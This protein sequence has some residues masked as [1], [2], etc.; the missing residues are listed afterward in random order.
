MHRNQCL[1]I[2]LDGVMNWAM[3]P[4]PI[5][6]LCLQDCLHNFHLHRER[7]VLK[8]SYGL[9]VKMTAKNGTWRSLGYLIKIDSGSKNV[10][11]C[12]YTRTL[13]CQGRCFQFS[14]T[15]SQNRR[16]YSLEKKKHFAQLVPGT[17]DPRKRVPGSEY[18]WEGGS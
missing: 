14:S 1:V 7:R 5:V 3:H 2:S 8:L 6:S 15:I 18:P 16:R 12:A 11:T 9:Y 13:L 4:V 10:S 17:F